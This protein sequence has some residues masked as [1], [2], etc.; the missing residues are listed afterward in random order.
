MH[1]FVLD[2]SGLRCPLPLLKTKKSLAVLLS[3]QKLEVLATD[4][5]AE[6]DFLLYDA[7]VVDFNLVEVWQEGLVWHFVWL[8]V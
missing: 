8:K 3:G 2:T 6:K 1:D 7:Q 4:S 5:D